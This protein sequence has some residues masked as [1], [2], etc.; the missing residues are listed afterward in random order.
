MI[1]VVGSVVTRMGCLAEALALSTAHVRRSRA[2]DGCISHHVHQDVEDPQRLV[3]V[4]QWGT[5]Q[6]LWSH[7]QVPE[8]QEFARALNALAQEPPSLAVY[9]AAPVAVPTARA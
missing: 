1:L 4:E 3:F 8:S 7:F 2:E 6:A 9:D 5:V